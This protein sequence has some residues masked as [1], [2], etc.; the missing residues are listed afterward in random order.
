MSCENI[1]KKIVRSDYKIFNEW[2]NS[3]NK[4]GQYYKKI[5]DVRNLLHIVSG[6]KIA[7]MIKS[8]LTED[9]LFVA[10][11]SK[12]NKVISKYYFK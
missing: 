11:D 2:N 4:S 3:N 5:Q 8:C 1:I 9:E 6:G 10:S 12:L 7:E